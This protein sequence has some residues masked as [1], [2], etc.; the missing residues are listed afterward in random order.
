M[1]ELLSDKHVLFLDAGNAGG[2]E[3][4]AGLV[5]FDDGPDRRK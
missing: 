1:S 5:R 4:G 2:N 3:S